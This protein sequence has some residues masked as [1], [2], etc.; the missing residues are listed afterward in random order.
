LEV[1]VTV[2]D[3]VAQAPSGLS[4]IELSPESLGRFAAV[5]G[6]ALSEAD[7]RAPI[8]DFAN[9]RKR[10]EARRFSRVHLL[11]AATAA[12]AVLWLSAYLWQKLAEPT[13]ELAELQNQ[14]R[15]V[16]AQAE[17]YKDVTAQA[18]AINHWLAT[19]I[20]W[21]D[22]LE[23]TARRVRPKPLSAKD[24]PVANDAV[25][26][27]LTIG[28]PTGLDATGGRMTLDGVAK[29]FAA[30]K[31]LEGRLGDERH[32]V[33]PGSEKQDPTTVPGYEWSFGVDIRVAPEE[34]TAKGATK[35]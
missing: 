15:D 35:R 10:V 27:Q 8:V 12:I 11:A 31:D 21:L 34:N 26:T 20:N 32:R 16:E 25:M 33:I 19:D 17:T 3:P 24:F 28:R 9:V 2:V 18:A 6:M 4:T 5:L 14:I 1:P 23:Q 22:E 29:S 30:V 7:R 13:R